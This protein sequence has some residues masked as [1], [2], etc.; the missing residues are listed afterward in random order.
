M[1]KGKT[2]KVSAEVVEKLDQLRHPGQSY[3]GVLRE[4]LKK[5]LEKEERQC[6]NSNR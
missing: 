2:I 3:D 4:L 6:V 5:V 1:R